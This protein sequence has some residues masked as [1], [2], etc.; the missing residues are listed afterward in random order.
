MIVEIFLGGMIYTATMDSELGSQEGGN[1]DSRDGFKQNRP[2]S[3]YHTV[4]TH[5]G[6]YVGCG[7]FQAMA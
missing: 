5:G 1:W 3:A 6:K 2:L 7:F 4:G